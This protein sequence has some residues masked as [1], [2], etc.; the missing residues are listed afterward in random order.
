MWLATRRPPCGQFVILILAESPAYS[1]DRAGR[2]RVVGPGAPS[3]EFDV[4]RRLKY[5]LVT[6]GVLGAALGFGFAVFV[7]AVF[8]YDP[9]ALARGDAVVVLT[10]GELRVREGLRLFAMGAGHRLLI[11]GVNPST[12][13]HDLWRLSGVAES[14][15]DCCVDVDQR[16]RDTAGNADETRAWVM[17]RGFQ[18]LVIVTSNYHMPRSLLMLRLALPG[19]ELVPHAVVAQPYQF[20]EWWRHPSAVKRVALEYLKLLPAAARLALS[21]EGFQRMP[22]A[23]PHAPDAAITSFAPTQSGL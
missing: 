6:L 21:R 5:L 8:T 18:R 3:S 10:G 4:G 16:A 13:R 12:T 22:P 23:L 9:Q 20:G 11:S 19:I 1:A 15:F 7:T 14:Q 17:S 2:T